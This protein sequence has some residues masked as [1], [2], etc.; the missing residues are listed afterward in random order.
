MFVVCTWVCAQSPSRHGVPLK[1]EL[2]DLNP[3][4][5]RIVSVPIVNDGARVLKVLRCQVSCG[6]TVPP[7]PL[8]V[9]PPGEKAS[10]KLKFRAGSRAGR[11]RKTIR[12]YFENETAGVVCQLAG[13]VKGRNVE[14][15]RRRSVPEISQPAI[16]EVNA[17][18]DGR[19]LKLRWRTNPEPNQPVKITLSKEISADVRFPLI[20]TGSQLNIPLAAN[21]AGDLDIELALIDP[22]LEG[23]VA[24]RKT[25]RVQI[26]KARATEEKSSLPLWG[27]IG[28]IFAPNLLLI[29]YRILH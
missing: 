5:R 19:T 11:F 26:P 1:I 7:K 21:A 9:I 4:E 16:S 27:V 17:G 6:C 24:G 28:L 13:N 20:S 29:G 25:F 12:I 10:L 18:V 14:M 3:G 23:G 15:R 8:P 22:S 2:G